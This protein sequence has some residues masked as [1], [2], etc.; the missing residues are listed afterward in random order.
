M[1]CTIRIILALSTGIALGAYAH[2]IIAIQIDPLCQ[3][4]IATVDFQNG[5]EESLLTGKT[6]AN[7]GKK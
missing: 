6:I 4:S 1:K 2:K 7:G 3:W 5:K